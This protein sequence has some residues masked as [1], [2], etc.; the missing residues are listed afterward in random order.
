MDD[1]LLQMHIILDEII[2]G[3]QVLETDSVEVVRA[4]EEISK[5]VS[6]SLS[7]AFVIIFYFLFFAFPALCAKLVNC[8]RE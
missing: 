8:F 1:C 4:V 3:G 6:L 7:L 5:F 2:L